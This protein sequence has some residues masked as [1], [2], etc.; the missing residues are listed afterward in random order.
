MS[1]N[2]EGETRSINQRE[3]LRQECAGRRNFRW[4]HARGNL[5]VGSFLER[6][7]GE[8]NWKGICQERRW[9]DNTSMRKHMKRTVWWFERCLPPWQHLPE[10][11]GGCNWSSRS[12][13]TFSGRL[14]Q[15]S[16]VFVEGTRQ[17]A[18]RWAQWCVCALAPHTEWELGCS[19]LLCPYKKM[20]DSPL[21]PKDK[22]FPHSS[23]IPQLTSE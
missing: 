12:M 2:W 13:E 17:L 6:K 8:A 4:P 9:E 22:H 5:A 15:E 23:T 21:S 14:T 19:S 18:C 10:G 3:S 20:L 11:G 16:I 7:K 1:A